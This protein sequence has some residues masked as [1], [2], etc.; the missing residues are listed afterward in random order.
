MD[1]SGLIINREGQHDVYNF[2]GRIDSSNDFGA[3]SV[4]GRMK[5]NQ[6]TAGCRSTTTL[7]TWFCADGS[8]VKLDHLTKGTRL[9]QPPP[10]VTKFTKRAKVLRT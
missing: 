3:W 8:V 1:E 10:L 4:E 6:A 7:A 9:E 2:K 5:F